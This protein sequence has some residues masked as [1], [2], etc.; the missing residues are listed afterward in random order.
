[1]KNLPYL[2]LCLCPILLQAQPSSSIEK[3]VN[4][5]F[6]K[7]ILRDK[8]YFIEK[9]NTFPKTTTPKEETKKL[10]YSSD[11]RLYA[12]KYEEIFDHPIYPTKDKIQFIKEALADSTRDAFETIHSPAIMFWRTSEEARNLMDQYFQEKQFEKSDNL[13]TKYK[14]FEFKTKS[15]YP[16]AYEIITN[17]FKNRPPFEE[18]YQHEGDLI[19]RLY[20][21]GE[22]EEAIKYL[23]EM[24][25]EYL[26]NPL[27]RFSL[28][29]EN[30]DIQ[31]HSIF[32]EICF[33]NDPIIRNK[34]TDLLF[35]ILKGKHYNSY[36]LYQLSAYLDLDRH[37]QLLANK[38]DGLTNLD[39]PPLKEFK[40]MDVFTRKSL[41]S[42]DR[43]KT[44]QSFIHSNSLY[45]SRARGKE[46]YQ[47]FKQI[48]PYWELTYDTKWNVFH[49][50]EYCFKDTS[51]TMQEKIWLLKNFEF[52]KRYYSTFDTRGR[53][54]ARFLNVLFQTFP[55]RNV[56]EDLYEQLDISQ[57]LALSEL[58][59]ITDEDLDIR[60]LWKKLEPKE[61][62][63]LL[64]DLNEYGRQNQM[65][66]LGLNAKTRFQFSQQS[67]EELINHYFKINGKLI[68]FNQESVFNP[69]DFEKFYRMEFKEKIENNSKLSTK[70]L[71][72]VKDL[73]GK[74]VRKEGKT[75]YQYEVYFS[76]ENS[77]FK[78]T[79]EE[80]SQ[81]W[82][83]PY[84]II[85]MI[86]L[87]L[88]EQKSKIRLV[89]AASADQSV[90]FIGEPYQIKTLL[91]KYK[92]AHWVINFHDDFQGYELNQ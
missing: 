89:T 75:K 39:L 56:P 42:I 11:L 67:C 47:F 87:G 82:Q 5:I 77:H 54:K 73:G 50:L 43:V 48:K 8:D 86:N 27:K 40:E 29:V 12:L 13:Y 55:D 59:K 44:L 74:F 7:E 58:A 76:I 41:G 72:F 18:R 91:S 30:H 14:Y 35:Q 57:F 62:D 90:F 10:K 49:T 2:F 31:Y 88:I 24:T 60:I 6:D 64:E 1:M 34:S 25:N 70:A 28:S 20:L 22:E 84:R 26:N 17:Y 9:V 83:M 53:F 45:L 19:Y 23:E 81:D 65:K 61:M 69:A 79:Y 71:S 78:H 52:K 16:D 92:I 80:Q 15:F 38:F 32:H 36:N 33:S 85:K 21:I 68:G 66:P 63:S 51:L 46:I 3:E 4:Q 37:V